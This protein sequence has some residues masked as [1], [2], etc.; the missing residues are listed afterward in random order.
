VHPFEVG[1]TETIWLIVVGPETLIAKDCE[2]GA[3]GGVERG[4]V[5]A[6]CTV[7]AAPKPDPVM[8]EDESGVGL[9]KPLLS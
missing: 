3:G 4:G 2:P 8:G 1:P 9:L 5:G 6:D 7:V